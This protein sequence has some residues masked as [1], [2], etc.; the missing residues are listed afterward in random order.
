MFA[1]IYSLLGYESDT[2]IESNNNLNDDLKNKLKNIK[3][4][5]AVRTIENS[6][7]KYLKRKNL[8]K[9]KREKRK[10]YRRIKRT[11][12]KFFKNM[13]DIRNKRHN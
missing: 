11:N 2:S 1:Y 7:I 10:L 5:S 13:S 9:R 4:K 3:E 8:K 6:Y 12:P